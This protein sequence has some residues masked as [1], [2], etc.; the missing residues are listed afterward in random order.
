M[1]PDD[2]RHNAASQ[3]MMQQFRNFL[4]RKGLKSTRQ[5]DLIVSEFA[6][7]R[8]HVS[9]EELLQRVR[10]NDSGVGTPTVYRTLKLLVDAGLAACRH[11]GDGF[12]RFEQFHTG[13]TCAPTRAGLMTGHHCNSTGVWHTII[14]LHCDLRIREGFAQKVFDFVGLH[15]HGA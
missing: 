15:R 9:V 5:R 14:A 8:G 3:Q 2:V 11:F 4:R 1:S 13:T 10:A 6:Q 12:T 7:V